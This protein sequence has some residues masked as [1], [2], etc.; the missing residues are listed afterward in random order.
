MADCCFP[1]ERRSVDAGM[2][3]QLARLH[4]VPL[5]PGK[6][7]ADRRRSSSLLLVRGGRAANWHHVARNAGSCGS[8]AAMRLAARIS[9]F[10]QRRY[11]VRG[12]A[13]EQIGGHDAVSGD[14]WSLLRL[15]WPP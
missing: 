7:A 3:S 15:L 13:P 1:A 4:V 9:P 2:T 5:R 10:R 14:S 8:L 6:G 11:V 12:K